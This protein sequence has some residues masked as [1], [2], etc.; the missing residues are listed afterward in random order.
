MTA[1]MKLPRVVIDGRMVSDVSHGISR[2]VR[3][4]AKGLADISRLEYE[5]VFLAAPGMSP[6]FAGFETVE[7][8]TGFLDPK[9]MLT[10]P[11][12]LW[13]SKAQLY[14]SPSFSSLLSAPCPW[15]VTIHDMNH[16]T[17]GGQLERVYYETALRSF[18]DRAK[19][20]MTVSEFSKVEIQNWN[21]KLKPEVVYNAI[22]P[23]FLKEG[24][25]IDS[26]LQRFGL[27]RGN[28]FLCLSNNKPHKNVGTLVRAFLAF[29]STSEAARKF[30]LV[31]SLREYSEEPGVVAAAGISDADAHALLRGSC[32]LAFPSV[33]EGF[34]LPPLE[35]AVLGAPILL[36]DI[37]AHRE[38][39]RDLGSNEARWVKPLSEQ[40]WTVALTEASS[41]PRRVSATSR[42]KLVDRYSVKKIGEAMDR[43]YRRVLKEVEPE[44]LK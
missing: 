13:K 38:A 42:A 16:I 12:Q 24:G 44:T 32:A 17:Y 23:Q 3:M 18:A 9:E 26:T 34:G 31:I 22:D 7:L 25:S 5:P 36:S 28:Y 8:R 33:Y 11:I 20:V 39:L 40:D 29:R 15:I 1:S 19:A 35:A 2:Y 4:I 30:K 14:H 37:P 43:I 6:Y 10:L 27:E 21:P 41:R